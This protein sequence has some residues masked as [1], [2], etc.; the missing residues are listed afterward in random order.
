MPEP[1]APAVLLDTCAARSGCQWRSTD[2]PK[3]RG[4]R[5]GADVRRGSARLAD[6]R[7]EIATLVARNRVQLALTSMAWFCRLVALLLR[8]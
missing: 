2:E 4:N 5:S 1:A 7:M 3:P 8:Q 6:Y